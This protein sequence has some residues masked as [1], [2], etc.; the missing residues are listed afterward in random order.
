MCQTF[1]EQANPLF[2]FRTQSSARRYPSPVTAALPHKS[3]YK[4]EKG[5][6]KLLL[7]GFYGDTEHIFPASVILRHTMT[8]LNV[9]LNA[10]CA[11]CCHLEGN[12]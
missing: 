7:A 6:K 9:P 3:E 2:E 1:T 12:C 5:K 11:R 8:G 10:A 4:L